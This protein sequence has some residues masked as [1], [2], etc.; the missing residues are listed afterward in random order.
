MASGK[1]YQITLKQKKNLTKRV[2]RVRL[3]LENSPNIFFQ[4]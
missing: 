4:T 2:L 1:L 3:R